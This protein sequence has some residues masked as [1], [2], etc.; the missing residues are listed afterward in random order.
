MLSAFHS[1]VLLQI[2]T[3]KLEIRNLPALL[4]SNKELRNSNSL[5][6]HYRPVRSRDE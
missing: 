5:T 3:A 4:Y 1:D 2:H 6:A